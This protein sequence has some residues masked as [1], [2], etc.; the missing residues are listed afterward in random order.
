MPSGSH[1]ILGDAFVKLLSN[2]G[3]EVTYITAMSKI[4]S[5]PNVT[6]VD[7]SSNINL[8][9]ENF[10]NIKNIMD[11]DSDMNENDFFFPIMDSVSL[12][13]IKHE[14]VQKI[15]MNESQ[16]FDVVVAEWMYNELY[17]GFSTVFNC[18]LIWFSTLEP[19]WLILRIIDEAS[20]PAYNPDS[21][22]TNII[23]YTFFE[24]LEELWLQMSRSF[25]R[26]LWKYNEVTKIFNEM[27][28]PVLS[29][30]G[31]AV[32]SYEDVRYNGSLV[33]GNS[34]V[35]LGQATRLPQSYKPIGGFHIDK[36]I[37]TLPKNVEA[38]M[39][40]AKHGVIYFSMGSNLQSSQWP[41]EIKEGLLR[42]L[43]Q[44]KQTVLW[45]FEEALAKVP[46][47][48]HLL[49]WAPQQSILA[50]PNCVLFI[51]HSGLLSTTEAVHFGVPIIGIPVFADQFV[52][53]LR[54][55]NIG[56]A[57]KVDLS[58]DIV[59]ELKTAIVDILNDPRYHDKAKELSMVYHDRPVTPQKEIVHWVEHVIRTNGAVHL[60]SPALFV[61]WYQK[62]YLDLI[63]II[64]FIIIMSMIFIKCGLQACKHVHNKEKT[65]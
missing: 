63:V 30:K 65:S 51:T 43:G 36:N 55:V 31:H 6:I 13:T 14:Q 9:P 61:P 59:D 58:Y 18:P 35:A 2:A 44:L 57:K 41:N 24:R 33:L 7:V 5:Y 50:H 62:T 11:K 4:T 8:F 46:S 25:Y 26:E 19:H 52:N 37:Q 3:H 54:A 15:L 23:P 53:I 47:N 28:A 34:Y 42:M 32:P 16:H 45:K 40:H 21:M 29:R 12:A 39:D 22:S 10:L 27:Y 60:R 1:G 17:A 56:F 38:I 48:V 20:N 64:V 49:K